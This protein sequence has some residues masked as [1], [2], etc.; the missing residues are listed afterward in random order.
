MVE[1]PRYINGQDRLEMAEYPAII[2]RMGGC[3]RPFIGL[4]SGWTFLSED[5]KVHAIV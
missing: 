1:N 4:S 2:L 3:F 5:R